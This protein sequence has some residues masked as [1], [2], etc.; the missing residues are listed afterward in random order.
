MNKYLTYEAT[1]ERNFQQAPFD[2]LPWISEVS[3]HF[4]IEKKIQNQNLFRKI[5]KNNLIKY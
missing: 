5:I 3:P 1:F 2:D 4:S